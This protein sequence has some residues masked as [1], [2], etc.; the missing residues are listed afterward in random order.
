MKQCLLSILCLT[1]SLCAVGQSTVSGVVKAPDGSG[2]P[3]VTLLIKG[4]TNGGTTDVNGNYKITAPSD[5][6]L[7]VSYIGYTTKEI[8]VNGQSTLDILLDEEAT[9]LAEIVVV[10][11]RAQGRTKLETPAP[12]DVINMQEVAAASP[13]VDLA[14]LLVATAPSFNAVRSQGGDLSSHVDPPTLR[15]LAPNQMLVLINGKRR[16]TSALL[17]G[18][19]TGTFAN[20]V[21]MSFIP[22]SSVARVE[23]LRDGAAAQYGSDAIAG[24]MNIVLKETKGKL[25]GNLTV[26]AFPNFGTPTFENNYGGLTEGERMLQNEV[27]RNV[28][29]ES[30]Q[31]DANY[32]FDFGQ[33]GFINITGLLRQDRPS[34]RAT[35]LDYARYSTYNSSYLMNERTDA[36]GNPEITN[37]ELLTALA[38][39]SY[40][41]SA[42][43]SFTAEQLSTNV[44]LMQAR[45]IS[46]YDVASYQGQPAINLGTIGFNMGTSLSPDFEFY[47]NGDLSFKNI[48]GFSCYY[49]SPSWNSRSGAA[50]LYPNGFRPQMVTDQSN[51][52][53]TAGVTG[54]AGDFKIDVS[55]TFGKNAMDIGMIN[56]INVT[57]GDLSPVDMDLG[58]HSFWQNT[59]NVD[60]SRFFPDVLEGLNVGVGAEMRV[61]NYQINAGQLES[62]ANGDAGVYYASELE[63]L[64][65][66]PDGMPI[67]NANSSP[68]V[69]SDGCPNKVF[70]YD[71]DG[72]TVKNWS[73]NNQ[74]FAGFGINNEANEYR[75]VM[76]AYLDV[77]MD[78]TQRWLVAGAAR[79]ESY[80]D[81]GSVLTGKFA[82]RYSVTDDIALRGSYSTGFR[83]P[84]L[85]EL[86]YSQTFTYFVNTIPA[87]A[88]IYPNRSTQARV[89]GIGAL[90]E[91]TS[92][93]ISVGF[94]AN[95][96]EGLSL[97]V[98]AY[99]ITIEDR[100]FQTDPFTASEAP[101][102][103]PLIG[104]GEA[105]F[106][107]NGGT[108]SSRGLEIV[109]NYNTTMGPGTLGLTLAATFRENKFE[110]A[111]VPALNTLLT[112]E[113]VAAKY[114][115]RGPVGQFETGTPTT[116]LIGT[117]NYS[118]GRFSL[119]VRPSYFGKVTSLQ[120]NMSNLKDVSASYDVFTETVPN[121]L[122][123]EGNPIVD[124]ADQEYS[125]EL[126][127]DLGLGYTISQ[128]L[129]LTIG[130]NNVFNNLPDVI[131]Y[132]NRD[133]GLYSNYQQGSG[134]AYYFGRLGFSF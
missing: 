13:Q 116:R 24:V 56:T 98:D 4:T 59:S 93:N 41:N 111:T 71:V 43:Q 26:G 109:A 85:Q 68:I 106:R 58:N 65:V 57:Y 19:Q 83:A 90:Q 112:D 7:V 52:Y 129:Q 6:V 63:E 84:S 96:V 120:S 118:L 97:T 110:E 133:F 131:R 31:F 61:E 12:V 102:L 66:G 80:D 100:I 11:S 95:I 79:L 20:A 28:D 27:P 3:G 103:E 113:E 89:L 92:T 87:D 101:V 104:D 37:P 46:Q 50:G 77:E 72:T 123:P 64:M 8:P 29:G 94:A 25:T 44:G 88:T 99:D 130:G 48:E 78:V 38:Q 82:T 124:F 21:D 5:A 86:N 35:V 32:G 122:D 23:I 54:N 14:Q 36:N 15:G 114:V 69:D 117:V 9:Q 134:G 91:E 1:L 107:V 30:Y 105:Q 128:N 33:D 39:G 81:F 76:G 115:Q 16:H 42:G 119:M 45:G 67:E 22:A 121:L 10:G 47:A 40:T 53:L 127:F 132:E 2:L 126:I 51:T 108:I 125:P 34:V 18:S 55:N 62:Y 75:T 49:R 74:C 60:V 70:A 73:Q 17:N